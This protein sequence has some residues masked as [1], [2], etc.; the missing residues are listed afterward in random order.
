VTVRYVVSDDDLRRFAAAV[1][2]LL[3]SDPGTVRGSD[4]K[5]DL[6]RIR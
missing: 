6:S 1:P 2:P 3:G 4:P 5:E